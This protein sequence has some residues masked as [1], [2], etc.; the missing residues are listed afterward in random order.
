MAKQVK[1]KIAADGK[2]NYEASGYTGGACSEVQKI[3]IGLGPVKDIV[4]TG[5]AF[6]TNERPAYNE[7][8]YGGQGA[9]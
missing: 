1:I 3:M 4:S 9:L 2:V 6:K 7:L 5:E 8:G